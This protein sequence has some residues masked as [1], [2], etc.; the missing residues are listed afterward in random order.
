MATALITGASSGIGME[1][2]RLLAERRTDLVLVARREAILQR[3]KTEIEGDRAVS[4]RVAAADLTDRQAVDDLFSM[5]RQDGVAIDY[6]INN[7]G[8]GTHGRFAE[9]D[10]EREQAM[11]DLNIVAL[12]R[13]TR[14]FLPSMIRRGRGRVLNVAS[15]A[16]FQP[17]PMMSVYWASKAYV[18]HFSEALAT[19]LRGT[20]V[21]VTALCPGPTVTAFIDVAGIA[22]APFIKL[23]K[24]A[25]AGDVAAYGIAS[26][27]RGRRVAIHGKLNRIAAFSNRFAPRRWIAE[28]LLRLMPRDG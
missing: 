5:L 23:M 18:L 1:M 4:V 8:F 22:D 26:M 3:L 20:G 7:A 24:P 2:A 10:L 9:A 16:A 19:E 17:G 25:A 14:H 13:L 28:L 12:T 6:L 11:I 21:T 15:T 27:M